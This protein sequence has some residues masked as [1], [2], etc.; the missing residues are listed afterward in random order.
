MYSAVRHS[1]YYLLLLICTVYNTNSTV[2]ITAATADSPLGNN[3]LI[4][5]NTNSTITVYITAAILIVHWVII[6]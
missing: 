6:Y 1:F 5:Y 4:V 3:I 2:Y